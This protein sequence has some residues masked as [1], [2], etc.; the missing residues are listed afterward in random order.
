MST[1]SKDSP[2]PGTKRKDMAGATT[3]DGKPK[4]GSGSGE[5]PPGN[6]HPKPKKT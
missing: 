5:P 1:T 6:V 4:T 3:D 2:K